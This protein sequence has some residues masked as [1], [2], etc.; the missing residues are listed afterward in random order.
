MRF[1]VLGPLTVWPLNGIPVTIPGLKV[2]ALLADLLAHEGRP[3]SADRLID[4]LWAEELPGNPSGALHAKVSQLRRALDAVEPGARELVESGPFGYRLCVSPEAVDAG[5]VGLLLARAR[6]ARD[7]RGKVALLTEALGLWRGPTLGEVGDMEFARGW[8]VRLDEQRLV[9]FEDLAEARLELGEHTLLVGE[10]NDM[11]LQHP[12]RERLRAVQ[13]RA[14]YASGRQ[15]EALDAYEQYRRRLRDELGLDPGTGLVDLHQAILRR[16][17]ALESGTISV[18]AAARPNTNIPVAVSAE[19]DGGLVGRAAAIADVRKALETARLVTLTG[20]G[21]VGKT[22]L[23]IEAARAAEHQYADGGWMV[24]LAG[25]VHHVT[26]ADD[27]DDVGSIATVVAA[28]LGIRED[29][30]LGVPAGAARLGVID[31][32][33]AA[34][35]P[36]QLLLVLDNCEHVIEPVAHLIDRL[37]ATAPNVS[38]LVT[39]QEP[40]RS[41]EE[42]VLP[43]PPLELPEPDAS[44]GELSQAAAVRLFIVRAA[45]AAPAFVLS[46]DNAA[47]VVE[48][49]RRLDG[50][51]LALELAAARVRALDVHDLAAR[52][53]DRFRLLGSGH[54][55]APQRQRTLHA[56]IDWS[57]QRLSAVDKV[58]LRRLAVHVG[59]CTLEAAEQVC[60]DDDIA[61]ADV[62]DGLGRL[63]DRSLIAVSD[64]G[65]TRRYRLLES[66]AAYTRQRLEEAGESAQAWRRHAVYYADLAERAGALLRGTGQRQAL[67]SLDNEAANLRAAL[68][69]AAQMSDPELALRLVNSLAWYWFLRGRYQEARRCLTVAL[70]I[71]PTDTTTDSARAQ[72]SAWLA[73]VAFTDLRDDPVARR[74]A[75]LGRYDTIDDQAG[76]ARARWLC[77]FT[78]LGWGDM[79]VGKQLVSG[80]L[81]GFRKLGDRWGIAAALFTRAEHALVEGDLPAV[82][83]D[84]EESLKLF[85]ELGDRWGRL[86]PMHLLGVLA[87][88][89]G[90]YA[91]AVRLHRGA[92]RIAEDVELWPAVSMQLASLGRTSLLVED[93]AEAAEYHQRALGLA[94]N[95]SDGAAA[96]FAAIGLALGD[97][98]QGHLDLAE[99]RLRD[100]LDWHRRTGHLPGT[101]LVLAELGFVA[102]LRGDAASAREL[103][104]EGLATARTTGDV[105]AVALAL[106]G[107]SGAAV[108]S[109]EP[110]YGA[111]LL[112]AAAAARQAASAPAPAAERGDVDRISRRARA[113]LGESTFAAEFALGGGL[114]VDELP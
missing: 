34:L 41:P 45:A 25:E 4:D 31:R 52:L 60:T 61:A 109:D 51:P 28:T 33:A 6:A 92:L 73:G 26:G 55:T 48:I 112:G 68:D 113:A 38:V 16:D 17:P 39:S 54:R 71:P 37:L 7:A 81:A 18:A 2:R 87:E 20:P 40:V 14:L 24:E 95:Q 62:V 90:D 10:L 86:Q 80:A 77:A 15:S 19:P 29:S 22:R 47:A 8:V 11:I 110:G 79:A 75:V 94:E 100:L 105:R 108:L 104:T 23:A 1:G 93:F 21:G 59:G 9:A 84:S 88:I 43:V 76:Q 74:E 12:L 67:R 13:L 65:G 97:R 42:V 44:L 56:M 36:R 107:L 64:E 96:A 32:L 103:H 102:E 82:R 66:V 101:A 63:V 5:Q 30:A 3:V 89:S 69:T 106:E 35:R 114:D 58:L 85:D 53:D 99:E 27:A 72:A 78:M 57:W 98:R 46:A 70:E 91:H 49:C 111:R 50:I 83:R